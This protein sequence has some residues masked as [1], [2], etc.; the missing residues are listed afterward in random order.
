MHLV[1]VYGTLKKGYGNHRLLAQS[2]FVG[3]AITEP[4]FTM[5]HLGGFP[6]IVQSGDTAIHGEVYRVSNATLTQLDRLEGHPT[7]YER[8]PLMVTG[9]DG[10]PMDV[11]GYVLP[12]TW[13]DGRNVIP[14][15]VWGSR[16][17][18]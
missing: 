14:T 1:F 6:G 17:S 5:L 15:G 10:S 18:S 12:L 3:K 11:Q 4:N 13:L 9:M 8:K 7:F 16:E 2:M